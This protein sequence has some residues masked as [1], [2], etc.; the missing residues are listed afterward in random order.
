MLLLY[1]GRV[2]AS[3]ECALSQSLKVGGSLAT[4]SS[5]WGWR[6][7]PVRLGFADGH[8]VV[9]LFGSTVLVLAE[10]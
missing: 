7:N 10:V 5:L 1:S 8:T 4:K 3:R 2:R 9:M 6:M